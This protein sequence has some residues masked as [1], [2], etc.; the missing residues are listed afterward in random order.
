MVTENQVYE[1]DVRRNRI[2]REKFEIYK[3]I[4]PSIAEISHNITK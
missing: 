1:P 2:Y 4:Y 3:Q